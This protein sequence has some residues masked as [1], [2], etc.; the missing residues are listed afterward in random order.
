MLF[1]IITDT[2]F[3]SASK[4]ALQRGCHGSGNKKNNIGT[5]SRVNSKNS[6]SIKKVKN[7]S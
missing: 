5:I 6:T 1:K 3:F 7:N 4:I 2:R